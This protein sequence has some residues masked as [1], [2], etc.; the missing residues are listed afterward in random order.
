MINQVLP[1]AVVEQILAAEGIQTK[2]IRKLDLCATA[3]VI[4]GMNIYP[5]LAIGRVMQKI[6]RGLRF[7]WLDANYDVPKDSALSYRRYQLGAPVMVRLF[8]HVCRPIAT[9]ESKRSVLFWS[10][11]DGY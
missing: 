8:H 5:Y 2:R 3:L 1:T 6:S 10:T 9:P 11:G 7:I 4:I